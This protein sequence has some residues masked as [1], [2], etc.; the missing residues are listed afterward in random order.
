MTQWLLEEAIGELLD[1][2]TELAALA[3]LEQ[4]QLAD[5]IERAKQ[6]ALAE[7]EGR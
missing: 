2:E 7:L 6:E 5:D 4:R 3:Q 1:V